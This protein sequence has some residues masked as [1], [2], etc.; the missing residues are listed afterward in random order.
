MNVK[1]NNNNNNKLINKESKIKEVLLKTSNYNQLI[2]AAHQEDIDR[3]EAKLYKEVA[4]YS[5]VDAQLMGQNP[6][7]A[8]TS[9]LTCYSF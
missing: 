5:T 1:I 4:S 2:L 7:P 8:S 9:N 3:Q 6:R